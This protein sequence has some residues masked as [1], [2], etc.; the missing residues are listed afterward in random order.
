[1]GERWI[2][3]SEIAEL[4]LTAMARGRHA[5]EHGRLLTKTAAIEQADAP[6]W[7]CDRLRER[8]RGD[9]APPPRLRTAWIAWNDAR[10][11]VASLRHETEGGTTA[12]G[13]C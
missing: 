4:S 2:L 7:L 11:T 10:R 1:M 8:R 13:C 9:L 6:A 3:E 12:D 5:V